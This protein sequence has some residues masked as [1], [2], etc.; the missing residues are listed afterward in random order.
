M[1]KFLDR[2]LP[3]LRSY[4]AFLYAFCQEQLVRDDIRSV[5][6]FVLIK[7]ILFRSSSLQWI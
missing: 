1:Q 4:N 2:E 5:S 7:L 6:F 3:Y